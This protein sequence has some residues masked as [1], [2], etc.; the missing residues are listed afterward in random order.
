VKL[1]TKL[2]DVAFATTIVGPEET[3]RDIR[4]VFTASKTFFGKIIRWLTGGKVSHVF[5][6][7]DSSLWGGR[8]V[9]EATVGGVRKVPSYKARHN[10][11]WEYRAAM[12][13]R[14]ACRSIARYFGN[15]YDYAGL[16][17]FA[18]FIIAWRWL[19]LKAK[20]P[21]RSTKSQVCAELI[22]RWVTAYGVPGSQDWD[23]DRVTPQMIADA[24]FTNQP[25]FFEKIEGA[26]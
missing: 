12:D 10:V 3:S 8:W 9:A 20:K 7:Y 15:T 11:V 22:A 1:K 6:E 13:T 26:K 21:H 4:L 2:S 16:L 17:V 18:W 14:V 24:C 5:L 25:K 23:P 19:K